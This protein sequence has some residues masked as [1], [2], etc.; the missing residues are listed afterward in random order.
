MALGGNRHFGSSPANRN[1]VK[2]IEVKWSGP[3]QTNVTCW[4][5]KMIGIKKIARDQSVSLAIEKAAYSIGPDGIVCS[6]SLGQMQKDT[7]RILRDILFDIA[8]E[9]LL[10]Q[11]NMSQL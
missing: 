8:N 7:G 2:Y 3:S 11:A 9:E 6:I 4:L 10:Q 5:D 1:N